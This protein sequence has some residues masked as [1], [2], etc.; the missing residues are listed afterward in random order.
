MIWEQMKKFSIEGRGPGECS[1]GVF[2]VIKLDLSNA[3]SSLLKYK[4]SKKSQDLYDACVSSARTLLVLKGIDTAKDRE[5]FKQFNIN[6]VETGFVNK[7]VVELF[8][9]LLDYKLG[10]INDITSKEVEVEYVYNKVKEMYGSLNGQL[11]ITLPKEVVINVTE[12]EPVS[13]DYEVIDF[14][15]VTC[16]MNFV[17]VKIQL[18]K[19]KSGEKRGFY[20]DDGDPIKN[21][22]LSVSKEGNK[23]ILID[24]NFEGYNLLVVEKK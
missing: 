24:N 12:E 15:G 6:F 10:D 2:D 7:S 11:E 3:E 8:D 22:P 18:S 23:I 21:V 14:R 13:K 9:T 17:K 20:L 1:T 5:I 16:P 19:I 4:S